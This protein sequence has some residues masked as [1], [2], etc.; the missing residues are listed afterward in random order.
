MRVG[1]FEHLWLQPYVQVLEEWVATGGGGGGDGDALLKG[2]GGV[3]GALRGSWRARGGAG[4][5]GGVGREGGGATGDGGQAAAR[6][7]AQEPHTGETLGEGAAARA[8]AR[9]DAWR[10]GATYRY[11]HIETRGGGRIHT[12]ARRLALGLFR[13]REEF[14]IRLSARAL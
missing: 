13:D 7:T 1:S 10:G 12:R 11:R 3:G 9:D 6:D 2:A 4:D 14:L 5:A 8:W